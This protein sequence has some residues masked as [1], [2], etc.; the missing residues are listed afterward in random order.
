[1]FW[2][3]TGKL[4]RGLTRMAQ[5][6]NKHRS[7]GN[8]KIEDLVGFRLSDSSNMM[9]D[10]VLAPE[11]QTPEYLAKYDRHTLFYDCL[12]N[13]KRN[14][15][16]I[17]APRLLNLWPVLRDRLRSTGRLVRGLRRRVYPKFE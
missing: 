8:V 17:T 11:H 1:M 3:I 6:P 13:A 7:I 10:H 16:R 5:Q 12:H 14:Q 15:I 2:I 4:R 9:R